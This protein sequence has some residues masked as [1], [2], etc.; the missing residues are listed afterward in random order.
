MVELT[1]L[2]PS[3]QQSQ[4]G[5][6]E[7]FRPERASPG[8]EGGQSVEGVRRAQQWRGGYSVKRVFNSAMPSNS[9][10]KGKMGRRSFV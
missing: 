4:P 2:K 9:T 7:A 10:S 8:G 1:L 5:K 3:F 6:R